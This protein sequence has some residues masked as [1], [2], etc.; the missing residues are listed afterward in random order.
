MII[1]VSVVLLFLDQTV[2]YLVTQHMIVGESIPVI[3]GIFH[4][5]Y[6]LNPG[7]A[8]GILSHHQWFFILV[9]LLLVPIAAYVYPRIPI[10]FR[11][12]RLGMAL[13]LGGAVGNAVDRIRN[14]VVI[15]YLDFRIWPVF[16]LADMAIVIGV[17]FMLYT[18]VFRKES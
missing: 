6:I 13:L 18:I 12:A 3:N 14:G 2:K 7:A 8:F 10:R 5:T 15:D 16:N 4:L 9:A 17:A 11:L 1:L